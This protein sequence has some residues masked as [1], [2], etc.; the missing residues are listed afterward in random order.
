M[1]KY[2]TLLSFLF[3]S[4]SLLTISCKV[5][6]E[7]IPEPAPGECS[8]ESC[9]NEDPADDTPTIITSR[10]I[11]LSIISPS[12]STPTGGGMI[13]ISGS[14]FRAISEVY[15]AGQLC[16]DFKILK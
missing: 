4:F 5:V 15:I 16:T 8:G 6:T 3:S 7:V 13:E 14:G 2:P 12:G 9:G 10:Q 11:T 1:K